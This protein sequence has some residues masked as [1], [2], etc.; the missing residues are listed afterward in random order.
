MFT[1]KKFRPLANVNPMGLRRRSA[2]RRC[3]AAF[4][5]S[6]LCVAAPSLGQAHMSQSSATTSVPRCLTGHLR[7]SFARGEAAT[8]HR[9]WDFSLRN[10]GPGKCRLQGYPGV[11]L[12][13]KAGKLIA[14]NVEREG[15]PTP[16]VI[17]SV[18]QR[19]YFSFSYVVSG[20]CIPHFFTAY[21]LQ[22]IPPNRTHR[23]IYHSGRI[24]ICSPS[25]G[26]HPDV[27]PIR[28]GLDL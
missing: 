21:G 2:R 14:V 9:F 15:G 5:L 10:V 22:I 23:L 8:S 11:G 13:N 16:S 20:P 25:V 17:V 12:L 7:L 26:G 19:A 24:D 18:G 6:S 1:A 4:L 27:Y 3:A 28:A